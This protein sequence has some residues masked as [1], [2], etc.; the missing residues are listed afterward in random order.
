MYCHVATRSSQEFEAACKRIENAGEQV[1]SKI[2][3][4]DLLELYALF[5]QS[6][7]GDCNTCKFG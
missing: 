2:S 4:R 6:K 1:R 5:K 7:F 3:M